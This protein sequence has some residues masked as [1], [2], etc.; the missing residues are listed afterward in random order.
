M[1][2]KTIISM[3]RHTISLGA[4]GAV[5]GLYTLAVLCKLFPASYNGGNAAMAFERISKLTEAIVFGWFVLHSVMHEIS[6]I[7]NG[8]KEDGGSVTGINYMAHLGG[9]AAGGTLMLL[10]RRIS[11]FTKKRRGVF[12]D[13]HIEYD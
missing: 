12:N 8:G 11:T 5:F 13:K 1:A 3:I 4:S 9:V 7:V 6:M 2:Y 10:L